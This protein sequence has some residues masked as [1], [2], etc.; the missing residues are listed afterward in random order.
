M[1]RPPAKSRAR[2]IISYIYIYIYCLYIYIY[3]LLSY[4]GTAWGNHPDGRRTH[5]CIYIY[6][7]IYVHINTYIYIYVYIYAHAHSLARAH[8]H[9]HARARAHARATCSDERGCRHHFE[10]AVQVLRAFPK[11]YPSSRCWMLA[12]VLRQAINESAKPPQKGRMPAHGQ[13]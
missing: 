1:T 4:F 5:I 10:V 11:C 8:A 3:I 2:H 12:Q 7:F 6:I 9:A 13:T